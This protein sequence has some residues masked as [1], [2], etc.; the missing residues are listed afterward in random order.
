MEAPGLGKAS[1]RAP[2]FPVLAPAALHSVISSCG[3]WKPL[4][5]LPLLALESQQLLL[6]GLLLL[7]FLEKP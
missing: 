4:V 6:A 7:I 1:R 5:C 3:F 2:G